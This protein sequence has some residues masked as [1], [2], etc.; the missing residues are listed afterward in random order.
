MYAT[1]LL[2]VLALGTAAPSGGFYIRFEVGFEHNQPCEPTPC[3]AAAYPGTYAPHYPPHSPYAPYRAPATPPAAPL[4]AET[5]PLPKREEAALMAARQQSARL[6]VQA[7][8]DA[9]LYVDGKRKDMTAGQVQFTTPLLEPGES[10]SYMLRA[11][12]V[13]PEGTFTEERRIRIRAGE[14]VQVVFPEP[15]S[16]DVV[17]VSVRVPGAR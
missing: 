9:R 3:G 7:P 8:S 2:T 12:V 17:R 4:P 14:V 11:V 5:L 1:S 13:R 16:A 6:H 10:Y 15:A